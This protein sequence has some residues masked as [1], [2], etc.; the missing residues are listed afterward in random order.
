VKTLTKPQS[1]LIQRAVAEYADGLRIELVI[2]PHP[3]CGITTA[4]RT[5]ARQTMALVLHTSC[6][7]YASDWEAICALSTLWG[8]SGSSR[9]ERLARVVRAARAETQI[10]RAGVTICVEEVQDLRRAGWERLVG[11]L[12][13]LQRALREPVRLIASKHRRVAWVWRELPRGNGSAFRCSCLRRLATATARGRGPGL[14]RR[15]D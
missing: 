14:G 13:N 10:G 12:E 9:V 1:E 7:H 6:A 15:A 5:A 8:V 4:L 3:Y 2:A 11:V